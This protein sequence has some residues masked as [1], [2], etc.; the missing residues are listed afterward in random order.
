MYGLRLGL[1]A[2]VPLISLTVSVDA[3]TFSVLAL[4]PSPTS[5]PL[6]PGVAT[7]ASVSTCSISSASDSET[8]HISDKVSDA[9]FCL[10][11]M[12]YHRY[13]R[14]SRRRRAY[15]VV[16]LPSPSLAPS[17]SSPRPLAIAL[18]LA[19]AALPLPPPPPH[20]PR[21]SCLV[22]VGLFTIATSLS[23]C[24]PRHGCHFRRS[25]RQCRLGCCR[26]AVAV[27]SSLCRTW[28]WQHMPRGPRSGKC[29]HRSATHGI[30][31]SGK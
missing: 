9:F 30:H 22:R 15:A 28:R 1:V 3:A 12:Y 19:V 29:D 18:T 8:L 24:P 4:S 7:A 2:I 27:A 5:P 11:T 23:L 16:P 10:S 6:C 25:H 13:H 14:C 20:L 21:R 26:C 17:K 31:Y